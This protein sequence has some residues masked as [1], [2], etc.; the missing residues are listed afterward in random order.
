MTRPYLHVEYTRLKDTEVTTMRTGRLRSPTQA[1]GPFCECGTWQLQT[2]ELKINTKDRRKLV[3]KEPAHLLI[4][5][6][7]VSWEGKLEE[8]QGSAC[9]FSRFRQK[10][11]SFQ[12]VLRQGIW[13]RGL[14]KLRSTNCYLGESIQSD[15]IFIG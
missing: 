13:F 2:Q 15:T 12:K 5:E 9:L 14:I 7:T 10:I 3:L 1:Q 6:L 8:V 4:M 11:E